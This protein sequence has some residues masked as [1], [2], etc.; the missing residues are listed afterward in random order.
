MDDGNRIATRGWLENTFKV[1]SYNGDVYYHYASN[2][3]LPGWAINWGYNGRILIRGT[4]EN[5]KL[6]KHSDLYMN[7]NPPSIGVRIAWDNSQSG[8]DYETLTIF[9][10]SSKYG[11]KVNLYSIDPANSA[12]FHNYYTALQPVDESDGDTWYIGVYVNKDDGVFDDR[13]DTITACVSG[14]AP[15]PNLGSV[16]D[17]FFIILQGDMKDPSKNNTEWRS[18]NIK[19]ND[20]LLNPAYEPY[21][22]L[23]LIW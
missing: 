16:G 5:N 2:Q 22:V 3:G 9:R 7:P 18:T 13:N 14:Y 11:T 15:Y 1:R 4:L 17:D 12:D 20:W 23:R 21:I 8:E 6:Y 19:Y 10:Y